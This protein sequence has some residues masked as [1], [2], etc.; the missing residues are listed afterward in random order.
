MDPDPDICS[1]ID[2]DPEIIDR[3]INQFCGSNYRSCGPSM[4]TLSMV[5]DIFLQYLKLPGAKEYCGFTKKQGKIVHRSGV[6][7]KKVY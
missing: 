5:G 3:S 4:C 7:G 2:P 6:L 1:D